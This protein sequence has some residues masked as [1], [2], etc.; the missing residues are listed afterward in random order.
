[1]KITLAILMNFILL[2]LS[3]AGSQIPR[4]TSLF[5]SSGGFTYNYLEIH[6]KDKYVQFV[7]SG[8]PWG[9]EINKERFN[10]NFDNSIVGI[11]FS[12]KNIDCELLDS[13]KKLPISC[14]SSSVVFNFI[15]EDDN[16]KIIQ[17]EVKSPL[18]YTDGTEL[19][20]ELEEQVVIRQRLKSCVDLTGLD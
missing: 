15:N 1:M 18:I 16:N 14:S 4:D 11:R 5:C 17:R 10:I 7:A 8:Y 2:N 20:V 12:L 6:A 3:F 9:F 13:R 19:I